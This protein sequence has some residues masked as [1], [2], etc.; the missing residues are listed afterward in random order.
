MNTG[1]VSIHRRPGCN[2]R[3]PTAWGGTAVAALA[4]PTPTP[5]VRSVQPQV[6]PL[7]PIVGR[8]HH[9]FRWR[10]RLAFVVSSFLSIVLRS[11]IVVWLSAGFSSGFTAYLQGSHGGIHQD[12]TPRFYLRLWPPHRAPPPPAPNRFASHPPRSY[13]RCLRQLPLFFLPPPQLPLAGDQRR[14]QSC[15]PEASATSVAARGL[16]HPRT[17]RHYGSHNR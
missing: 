16:P 15:Q 5:V 13:Q 3:L 6:N 1:V 8:Q 9:R 2:H 17:K 7:A 4:H 12:P 14:S 10:C 11:I